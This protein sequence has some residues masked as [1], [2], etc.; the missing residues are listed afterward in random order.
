VDYLRNPETG[1]LPS[2]DNFESLLHN[3]G[4]TE[5]H[6]EIIRRATD[7]ASKLEDVEGVILK[8]SLGKGEGDVFSD[9]DFQI[10]HEGNRELSAAILNRFMDRLDE[11]GTMIHFFPS[12]AS[13]ADCIIYLEPFVK[14]ELSVGTLADASHDWK[15]PLA[16]ILFDKN[17]LVRKAMSTAR[18]VEFSLETHMPVIRGRAVAIPTF[19]Y[20][21]G[22]HFARGEYI[23]A[24]NAIDWM[25]N[26]ML[27]ISGWLLRMWDEGP[28]R[29]E[30]RFPTDVLGYYRE[31]AVCT[32]VGIWD[33][34]DVLLDWYSNWMVPHFEELSIPHSGIQVEQMRAILALLEKKFKV[35]PT[36]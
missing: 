27:M 16:E 12:T 28:R 10:L 26:D 25:R 35:P 1:P 14:F 20:I 30:S 13:L 4:T 11:V 32:V 7:V 19:C 23:T 22:G 33:S 5:Y 18:S 17:G 2:L 29:A 6:R 9:I 15:T 24:L 8:G 3:T 21:T 31:S 36:Q 34:L